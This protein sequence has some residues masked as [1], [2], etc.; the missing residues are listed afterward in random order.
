VDQENGRKKPARFERSPDTDLLM[1]ALRKV[2]VGQ[3]AT[4]PELSAVISRD[5][6]RLARSN[7]QSARKALEAQDGIVFEAVHNV[8]MRRLDDV[9]KV[10]SAS[11]MLSGLRRRSRRI[12]RRL[13]TVENVAELSAPAKI[14][15]DTVATM[16]GVLDVMTS[17]KGIKKI[18][19]RVEA[20]QQKLPLAGTLAEFM[21]RKP[22]A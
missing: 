3:T 20:A 16:V 5:V 4:Y 22:D 17:D 8:G 2:E 15:F 13:A 12:G 14:T 9:A 11:S 21:G 7:L 19:A 1:S 6:Q 10:K 18:E